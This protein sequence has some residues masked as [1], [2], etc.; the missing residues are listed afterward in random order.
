MKSALL[1]LRNR[2]L[3]RLKKTL[4]LSPHSKSVRFS[5][6]LKKVVIYRPSDSPSTT[7]SMSP[8]SSKP[9]S[10]I[11]KTCD[12]LC[13]KTLSVKLMTIHNKVVLRNRRKLAEYRR[14]N[15]GPVKA[16]L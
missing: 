5:K 6:T 7:L 3:N 10:P 2:R 15:P 8:V 14:L 9:G 12:P 16:W 11:K 13:A 4:N 1:S